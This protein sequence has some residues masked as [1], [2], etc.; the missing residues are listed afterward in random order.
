M[1]GLLAN[2]WLVTIICLIA[3]VPLTVKNF[4]LGYFGL[5][6]SL[7]TFA[8]LLL[9]DTLFLHFRQYVP[10]NFVWIISLLVIAALLTVHHFGM[11]AV[12]WIF[13]IS[14]AYT[15][16][17]PFK[18][19]CFFN[20]TLLTGV[21]IISG[22]HVGFPATLRIMASFL[23]LCLISSMLRITIQDLSKKLRDQSI[24]DPMTGALN[25]RNLDSY[26]N[27]CL[28]RKKEINMDSSLI[29]I[30]IDHFKQANDRFGHSFGD[31]IIEQISS[32]I[33]QNIRGTD[34]LFRIGGDEFLTIVRDTKA[35]DAQ[36]IATKISQLVHTQCSSQSF[37]ASISM[38]VCQVEEEYTKDIWFQNADQALYQAKLAG[39]NC[40]KMF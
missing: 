6:I 5:G 20:L 24:K 13:P 14:L 11:S 3:C 37:K 10:I 26:L 32:I 9:I 22:I 7:G 8:L 18:W 33:T 29:L 39:R 1:G 12:F 23:F 35:T 19:A 17:I 31:Q 40:V 21:S 36:K 15:F 16:M 28:K 30:D 4:Y 34:L 27:H 38:G 2:L 25:R